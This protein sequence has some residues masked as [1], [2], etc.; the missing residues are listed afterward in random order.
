MSAANVGYAS[1]IPIG[2]R[3]VL[4]QL[5]EIA[6]RLPFRSEPIFFIENRAFSRTFAPM[7]CYGGIIH[8]YV[9]RQPCRLYAAG[10]ASVFC[11]TPRSLLQW[12][13][14]AGAFVMNERR[15]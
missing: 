4:Y 6:G 1:N 12:A 10:L 9:F 13:D 7:G 11:H 5:S 8:L 14:F 15:S 3:A 2:Q